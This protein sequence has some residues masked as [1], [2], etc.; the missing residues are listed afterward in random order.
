MISYAQR[1]AGTREDAEPYLS[2]RLATAAG[3]AFSGGEPVDADVL[4]IVE[5]K[6]VS[7]EDLFGFYVLRQIEQWEREGKISNPTDP[8]IDKLIRDF[9]AGF[10]SSAGVSAQALSAVSTFEGWRAWYNSVNGVDYASGYRHED[11]YPS[12]PE[13]NRA[14]NGL[15]DKVADAR[16][17]HIIV[18]IASALRSHDNVLV[19]YGGS[20]NV[21]EGPALDAAFGSHRDIKV[22]RALHPKMH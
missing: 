22:T 18:V 14:S 21:I 20:H 12:S 5:A 3:L 11:A 13:N 4:R 16:D 8:A 10:Q 15:S 17:Q 2:I 7:A 19:V 9:A 6:G 1:V